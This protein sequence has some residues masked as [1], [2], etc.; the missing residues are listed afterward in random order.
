MN[1]A[2]PARRM[3]I[4]EPH[5][6]LRRTVAVLARD[7]GL[8]TVQ[9]ASSHA[10]AEKLLQESRFDAMLIALD[11]RGEALEL[12]RQLRAGSTVQVTDLPVAATATLCDVELALRLKQLDVSRLLIKPFKV[13]DMLGAITALATPG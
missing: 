11:E 6:V 12:L 13:R 8:V 10:A 2:L 9:E 7:L 4:V 5:F 1:A 3:L